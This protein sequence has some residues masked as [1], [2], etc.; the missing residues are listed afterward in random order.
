MKSTIKLMAAMIR[1][2]IKFS[3]LDDNL[4]G[5]VITTTH[6]LYPKWVTYTAY[7]KKSLTYM[8]EI[9][10][11]RD[12]VSYC[13]WDR[14]QEGFYVKT[15]EPR[16][17]LY[18]GFFHFG[19][20]IQTRTYTSCRLLGLGTLL[21]TEDGEKAVEFC[22]KELSAGGS[23]NAVLIRLAAGYVPMHRGNR[24]W[25][26]ADTRGLNYNNSKGEF[27]I[28]YGL[29]Q[30]CSNEQTV[31]FAQ[32]QEFV[33]GLDDFLLDICTWVKPNGC[34]W[35]KLEELEGEYEEIEFPMVD[36][37]MQKL[38]NGAEMFHSYLDDNGKIEM[39]CRYHRGS[40]KVTRKTVPGSSYETLFEGDFTWENIRKEFI[41]KIVLK[42]PYDNTL[43]T[44]EKFFQVD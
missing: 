11:P 9:Q 10:I 23:I 5:V 22:V 8:D 4:L 27:D 20:R 15:Q 32:D 41:E 28:V 12:G 33:M 18:D 19:D 36:E 17:V 44:F 39:Y 40:F 38:L 14:V 42:V 2:G 21:D 1:K 43:R 34:T 24:V 30:E 31:V 37:D 26:C 29:S 25:L 16:A 13:E 35:G 7:S 3:T 6:Q